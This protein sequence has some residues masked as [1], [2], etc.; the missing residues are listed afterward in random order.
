M[1]DPKS[2]ADLADQIAEKF[3]PERII[4]FGSYASRTPT[5]DSDVDLLVILPFE[6]KGAQ[7]V[8][9]ILGAVN[10]RIP[11]DLVVRTPDQIRPS[12]F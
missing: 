4:L 7:K 5:D 2:I 1:V 8:A 11:V 6:G 9:E 10:P 12:Y 3:H